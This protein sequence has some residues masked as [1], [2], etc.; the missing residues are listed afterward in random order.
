MIKAVCVQVVERVIAH[1]VSRGQG[2]V[3]GTEYFVKWCGLPYSECT[4]EEEHL[5]AR[6]FQDKINSYHERRKNG[7]IPNKNCSVCVLL[8]IYSHFLAFC[9]FRKFGFMR[10][11]PRAVSHFM[12]CV[13]NALRFSQ[14]IFSCC[15]TG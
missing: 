10:D 7:K 4:W 2:E 15:D 8:G 9:L 3:E 1:Q 12:T 14:I 13:G 11:Y 5:I 6:R